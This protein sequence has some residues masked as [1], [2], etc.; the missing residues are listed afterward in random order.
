MIK[1][2]VLSPTVSQS[3]SLLISDYIHPVCRINAENGNKDYND[4]LNIQMDSGTRGSGKTDSKIWEIKGEVDKGF[5]FYWTGVIFRKNMND[6]KDIL[7]MAE[8]FFREAGYKF[9]IN[10]SASPEIKFSTGERLLFRM[11]RN[12]EDYNKHHGANYQYILFEEGTL[13]A[14]IMELVYSMMSTLRTPYNE[15]YKNEIQAG[16]KKK[17]ILKMRIT[18]NPFG[19]GKLALKRVFVD[20]QTYGVPFVKDGITYTHML[21]SYLDNP[22]IDD[23]YINNFKSLTNKEKRNAWVFADWNAKSS[24]AFGELYRDELFNLSPFKIPANWNVF[25]SM[26]WGRSEPFSVLW[27]AESDGSTSAIVKKLKDGEWIEKEFC[28]PEGSMILIYEYYGCDPDAKNN[29]TGLGLRATVVA[30]NIKKIDKKLQ[31]GILK[32]ITYIEDGVADYSI[33]NDDGNE[34]SIGG[35]FEKEDIFFD[36]CVKNRVAGVNAMIEI[37]Q[38]TIEH[39]HD[40]RHIYVFGDNCP[41]W[42]ENVFSLEYDPKSPDDVKTKGVPDHD[43]DATKYALQRETGKSYTSNNF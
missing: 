24:G 30:Q 28:P 22:Y 27:W 1:S 26:D 34:N 9:K 36:K 32:D 3:N 42:I 12:E 39:D 43:W 11:M 40:L 16:L 4:F 19:S 37:M 5:G 25:R 2:N 23:S 20:N 41:F 35:L 6:L 18:T 29:N 7:N 17:M 14:D 8:N 13:W 15:K 38:N 31:N 10:R 21:S 33:Y